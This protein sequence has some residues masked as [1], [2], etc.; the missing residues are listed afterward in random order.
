[1]ETMVKKWGNSAAVRLPSKILAAAHISTGSSISIEVKDRKIII[2]EIAKPKRKV[3]N[4]PFTEQEL[5]KEL[6]P[7]LAHAD[8]LAS[9][10]N[11]ELG[12]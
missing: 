11:I 3:F 10:L 1:M 6:T 12:E 8:N 7:S 5:L 2:E 4:L 9:A